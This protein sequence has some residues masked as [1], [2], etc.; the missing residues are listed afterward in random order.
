[1]DQIKASLTQKLGPFPGY[2]WAGI[3][4]LGGIVVLPMLKGRLGATS[5]ST[6]A[7]SGQVDPSVI[8]GPAGPPGASGATGPAGPPGPSGLPASS[9]AVA[10]PPPQPPAPKYRQYTIVHGDTLW[11]IAQRFLGNGSRW[12]EIYR[13]SS[14]RSGD[15]NLIYPGE[16]VNIPQGGGDGMGGATRGR[17]RSIGS[18]SAQ[19]MSP[20]HPDVKRSVKITQTVRGVGGAAGHRTHVHAVA[21]QAGVHPARL[22]ALNPH[23]SGVIRVH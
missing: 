16:V 17:G 15:P 22:L 12:P 2:V 7:S 19:L 18:R 1:M 21:A 5:A 11:G 8:Q 3:A 20:W 9:G 13:A 14:L 23:Y 4:I 6:S 10:Q